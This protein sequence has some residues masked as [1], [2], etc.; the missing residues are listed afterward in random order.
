[1]VL[2]TTPGLCQAK[3]LRFVLR[4]S[5]VYFTLGIRVSSHMKTFLL[6]LTLFAVV[7]AQAQAQFRDDQVIRDL[8]DNGV[9]AIA[10]RLGLRY[11]ELGMGNNQ[12]GRGR[13]TFDIGAPDAGDEGGPVRPDPRQQALTLSYSSSRKH[14]PSAAIR[15]W[16]ADWSRHFS[17]ADAE[18]GTANLT[19]KLFLADG[20]T[21]RTVL[22]HVRRFDHEIR[23][24]EASLARN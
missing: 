15:A 11:T 10:S 4:C 16:N 2:L 21:F 6:V 8:G 19:A 23:I 3:Q 24:F 7:L 17:N 1:M 13:Y 22:E 14:F 5:F 12:L 18:Y 20:M 9:E